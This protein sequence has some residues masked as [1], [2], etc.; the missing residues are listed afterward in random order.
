VKLYLTHWIRGYAPWTALVL[1]IA[2]TFIALIANGIVLPLVLLCFAVGLV[3]FRYWDAIKTFDFWAFDE[4]VRARM[5]S[6]GIREWYTPY[7]AAEHFC[8]PRIVSL[9]NEAAEKINSIMMELI[10]DR[11]RNVGIP[12]GASSLRNLEKEGA[13]PFS[14]GLTRDHVRSIS[15][16]V[17]VNPN[18]T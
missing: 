16:F 18:G 3:V 12:D 14:A 8:D 2:A 9:R 6:I 17:V 1:L 7:H 10:R 11:Y 4:W 5:D 15:G 13:K